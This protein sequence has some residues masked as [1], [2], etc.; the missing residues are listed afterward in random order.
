MINPVRILSDSQ[1]K[2][3]KEHRYSSSCQSLLDPAMQIFWNRVVQ[4]VP[5]WVAPNLITIVGLFINIV[6]SGILILCC[7][8]ATED[9]PWWATFMAGVGLFVYQ[10]LDAI[11]GKQARRTGSSNP[12]GELFDHG[13]DSLSTVFVSLASCCAVQLGRYPCWMLFQCLCASTLFYCAH[14]Q[15]YVS[16]TLQFGT[17]DVTEGQL[18]VVA[19]MLL[20]S[21][22][23]LLS[24]DIWATSLFLIS[25]N[26]LVTLFGAGCGIISMI[27][28]GGTIDKILNDGA[29]KSGSTVAGTSVLSPASPLLFVILP[30]WVIAYRSDE[31]VF[32]DQ[33][34]LYTL[35]FGLIAAKITNRL[36]VAHMCKSE[37]HHRDP[38]LLAPLVLMANQ[39]FN[40]LV[41]ESWLLV[42][43][44]LWVVF[45]LMR[46][47][48]GVC[49][50]ICDF[51]NIFL[52]KI[53]FPPPQ[54]ST[55]STNGDNSTGGVSTRNKK[56]SR[57]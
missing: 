35:M 51:L 9:A 39:Y 23:S 16:G 18:V 46:Y 29:G 48:G 57:S 6:T 11:D 47:C 14:W 52:F 27:T 53:P 13:C 43:A 2:K 20:S 34:I 24:L 3:L 28:P 31:A 44:M 1:L 55:S 56:K 5:L 15:T 38:A 17:I 7:P 4:F 25:L 45:D 12:L 50:E 21:L 30:A 54:Q 26:Q 41:P 49:L 36:V 37:I 10:T 33:P 40:T 32:H 19:V 42:L 8:T 22:S